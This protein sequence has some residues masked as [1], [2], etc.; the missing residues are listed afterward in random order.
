MA[1]TIVTAPLHHI[2]EELTVSQANSSRR[3]A[4]NASRSAAGTGHL[5]LP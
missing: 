2:V 5:E 3:A 4:V 1:H